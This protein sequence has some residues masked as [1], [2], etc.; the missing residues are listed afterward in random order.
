M[1]NNRQF[2]VKA[3]S[4]DLGHGNPAAVVII[5]GDLDAGSMQ[6]IARIN[7]LPETV[8]L[9]KMRSVDGAYQIRWFTPFQEVREAGHAT[10]AAQY[11]L[12]NY[13]ERYSEKLSL[14]YD[15]KCIY[16][17][18]ENH[19]RIVYSR[20][21]MIRSCAEFHEYTLKH[22]GD[23]YTTGSDAVIVLKDEKDV[24]SFSPDYQRIV[25]MGVRGLCITATS[26]E[27]DYCCRFFAPSLGVDEDG[28]TASAHAY[29]SSFWGD[30]LGISR[31]IGVQ[32]SPSKGFVTSL[33]GDRIE[34]KGSCHLVHESSL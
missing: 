4:G 32:H 17:E 9:K 3:F 12:M 23:L 25:D 21:Y 31:L 22:N 19:D 16:V 29:L 27:A 33:V 26:N 11:I 24:L 6:A 28:V 1:P 34:L 15:D 30:R 20:T 8:F 13:I 18:R 7:D 10:L 2:L 5:E 14:H